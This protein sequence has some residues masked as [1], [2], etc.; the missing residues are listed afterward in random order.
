MLCLM[1]APVNL[2][3]VRLCLIPY[4]VEYQGKLYVGYSNNGERKA[5]NNSAELAVIPTRKLLVR[6][7]SNHIRKPDTK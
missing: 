2:I 5:S 4:A 3:R 6:Q 7:K 1:T